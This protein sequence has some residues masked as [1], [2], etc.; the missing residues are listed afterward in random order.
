MLFP[1]V[2]RLFVKEKQ[3]FLRKHPTWI[4]KVTK[5][6]PNQKKTNDTYIC[7][8]GSPDLDS[9][10]WVRLTSKDTEENDIDLDFTGVR[11]IRGHVSH[12]NTKH[13]FPLSF[14]VIDFLHTSMV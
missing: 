7:Y 2:Q 5:T 8:A 14:S 6:K 3:F 11:N 10:P 1:V 9:R 4:F 13:I 12:M